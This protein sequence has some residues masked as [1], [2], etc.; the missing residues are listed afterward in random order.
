MKGRGIEINISKSKILHI[1]TEER[2]AGMVIV[3]N[4]VVEYMGKN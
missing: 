3:G 1:K 2:V 4:K